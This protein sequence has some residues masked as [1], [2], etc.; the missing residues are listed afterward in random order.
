[1]RGPVATRALGTVTA[2][3]ARSS[4]VALLDLPPH[5]A[6]LVEVRLI[7]DQHGRAVRAHRDPLRRRPLRHRRRTTPTPDRHGGVLARP[8]SAARWPP[9]VGGPERGRH[10]L[11]PAPGATSTARR[12]TSAR[13]WLAAAGRPAPAMPPPITTRSGTSTVTML[14]MPRPGGRPRPHDRA[15]R[16]LVATPGGGE[17]LRGGP[18][19]TELGQ[20]AG[21]G[22]RLDA[23]PVAAAARR[24]VGHARSGGRSRRPA[25]GGPNRSR[26]STTTPPPTPV[27]STRHTTVEHP[28]PPRRDGSRPA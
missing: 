6:L 23:A 27:P 24:P 13:T 14:A 28:W 9:G 1:M 22:H 12:R 26:P 16:P 21:A 15:R 3:L 4:E 17:H 8:Q 25:R 20:S 2:R 18:P 7:F 19:P 5:A 10:D 11:V